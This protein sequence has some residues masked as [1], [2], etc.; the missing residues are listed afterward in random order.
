MR[1]G[2]VA[3]VASRRTRVT[4]TVTNG[5]S[6]SASKRESPEQERFGTHVAVRMPFAAF[7]VPEIVLLLLLALIAGIVYL[8]VIGRRRQ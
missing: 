3:L 2:A 7:G 1:L 5:A 4:A 6:A 8:A